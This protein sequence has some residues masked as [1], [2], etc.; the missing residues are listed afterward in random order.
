MHSSDGET[1][2]E[3]SILTELPR[4]RRTVRNWGDD[5]LGPGIEMTIYSNLCP[6]YYHAPIFKHLWTNLFLG[7]G[8]DGEA[9]PKKYTNIL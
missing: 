6:W 5:D 1:R 9:C 3:E 4:P 8:E 2:L 7:V